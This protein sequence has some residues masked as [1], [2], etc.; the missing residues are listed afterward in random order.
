[1]SSKAKQPQHWPFSEGAQGHQA[2]EFRASLKRKM[3]Q[4]SSRA[5]HL[6]HMRND[7]LIV[8][9]RAHQRRRGLS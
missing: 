2:Q 5:T 9:G 6:E 4:A 1:M 3:A 8:G 7:R